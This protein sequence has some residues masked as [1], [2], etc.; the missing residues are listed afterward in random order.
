M[1]I[2]ALGGRS[3][4]AATGSRTRRPDASPRSSARSRAP[5][6]AEL[7]RERGGK[8]DSRPGRP[9]SPAR[10]SW[11]SGSDVLDCRAAPLR[12][13]LRAG[14]RRR[15][16]P[17]ADQRGLRA[18][19]P[20]IGCSSP[21]S[22]GPPPPDSATS[23]R[24]SGSRRT[25]SRSSPRTPT[26]PAWCRWRA[27]RGARR[28]LPVRRRAADRD[29]RRGR[30]LPDRRRQRRAAARERRGGDLRRQGPARR[31]PQSPPAPRAGCKTASA[32]L[33][34]PCRTCENL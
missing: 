13:Q 8:A 33:R 29:R 16:R 19:R 17:R 30:R 22:R 26:R 34:K 21:R 32:N 4:S 10:P 18:P 5:V 31:S 7:V 1:L 15:R 23:T 14:A 27:D 25:S 2:G 28:G 6:T 11:R 20:A 12:P 24:P 3:R 9:A